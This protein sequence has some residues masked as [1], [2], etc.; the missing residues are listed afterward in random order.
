MWFL[1]VLLVLVIF[2][3]LAMRFEKWH[4]TGPMV[5]L[6]LGIVLSTVGVPTPLAAAREEIFV[7]VMTLTLSLLLFADASTI[8]L[9][10]LREHHSVPLRL[11]LIGLPL[12][13]IF[14]ALG[15]RAMLPIAGVGV[16][17]LIGIVLAPTDVSLGLVMFGNERVPAGVRRAIN[18]ESG[19]NDG[20]AAPLVALAIATAV[21]ETENVSTPIVNALLQIGLGVAVGAA[22]GGVGGLLLR[23][24]RKA[25]WSTES[26]RAFASFG[27]AVLAYVCSTAVHG[28]GFV[29]AFT[30]GVIFGA[31]APDDAEEAVGFS[32]E[33]G[34]LLSLGVWL[35]FGVI[36]GPILLNG[37][38]G[39]MP[40][41]YAILSLT[42]FRMVP[43]ALSLWRSGMKGSTQ[44]FMGWFGPRGLASVI[45]LLDGA[46]ELK[47]AGID[48]SVMIATVGWTV[49]LSVILH[50]VSAGPVADWYARRAQSFEPE[51]PELER[52]ESF[53]T[54]MRRP[55]RDGS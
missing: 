54:R 35:A 3:L 32:E 25:G 46:V 29:A 44:L 30:G 8:G 20:L 41:F 48:T 37:Q 51:S 16:A 28:N 34:T 36:M 17:A 39:L 4:L 26:S 9:R 14:G 43:V 42:V 6:G 38:Q 27:L 18:V 24:S 15:A 31:M 45:F 2:S 11:L 5:F 13:W 52:T 50:G 21:A 53:T 7:A 23:S 49:V 19:L 40:I 33:T 10:Q 47:H 55:R 1:L 22:V 12:T